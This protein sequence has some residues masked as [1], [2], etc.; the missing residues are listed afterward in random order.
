MP[1]IYSQALFCIAVGSSASASGGCFNNSTSFEEFAEDPI[2]IRSSLS[3]G[4]ESTLFVYQP[5]VGRNAPMTIE[6]A[7][8]AQRD[9][10]FQ[11]RILSPRILHCTTEQVFW[12][13][14]KGYITQDGTK[15]WLQNTSPS[16]SL[17]G[18]VNVNRQNP[19]YLI[20]NWYHKVMMM[21]SRRRLTYTKDKLPAISGIARAYYGGLQYLYIAGIWTYKLGL[22]LGWHRDDSARYYCV[23]LNS[24]PQI[25]GR[26]QTL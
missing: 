15:T 7:P 4:R 6:T 24:T 25:L 21:F 14:R 11:E 8:V 22:A 1:F 13:C 17:S 16:R 12:E 2:V 9:W 26:M 19:W 3:D 20:Q 10:T 23:A 18:S 5:A